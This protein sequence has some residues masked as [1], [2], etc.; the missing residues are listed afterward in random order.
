M[1]L[2]GNNKHRDFAE[3][4]FTPLGT[5]VNVQ[6]TISNSAEVCPRRIV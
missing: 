5:F 3:S 6:G 1:L 4:L 2:A